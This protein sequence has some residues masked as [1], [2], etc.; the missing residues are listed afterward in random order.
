MI[1]VEGLDI[2]SKLS[3]ILEREMVKDLIE[4]IVQF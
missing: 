3:V 4:L 1:S 2:A